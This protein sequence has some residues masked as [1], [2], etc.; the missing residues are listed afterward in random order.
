MT[1]QQVDVYKRQAQGLTFQVLHELLQALSD[2][3]DA[4]QVT[5]GPA[6]ETGELG[7]LLV[8]VLSLIHI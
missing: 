2:I 5:F 1:V 8:Q 4:R 6:L 3:R 7:D